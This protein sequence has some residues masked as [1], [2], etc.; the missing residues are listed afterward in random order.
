M[1]ERERELEVI[2]LMFWNDLIVFIDHQAY[3]TIR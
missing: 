3:E 2:D 1:R